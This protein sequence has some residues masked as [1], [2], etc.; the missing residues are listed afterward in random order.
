MAS[1]NIVYVRLQVT[2]RLSHCSRVPVFVPSMVSDEV[3]VCR[4][5]L[6]DVVDST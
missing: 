4:A 3:A 5:R 2:F 1:G 6:M